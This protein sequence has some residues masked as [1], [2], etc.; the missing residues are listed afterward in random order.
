MN[1]DTNDMHKY[2]AP[3]LSSNNH[4]GVYSGSEYDS[5]KR[6]VHRNK[7]I[8]LD[9]LLNKSNS[10]ECQVSLLFCVL[11]Y[12]KMSSHMAHISEHINSSNHK[13]HSYDQMRKMIV[14][15]VFNKCEDNNSSR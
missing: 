7:N 8:I 4:E 9:L 3:F 2:Y 12:K 1:D 5:R 6:R 14:N 15:L 13:I 10:F 11:D